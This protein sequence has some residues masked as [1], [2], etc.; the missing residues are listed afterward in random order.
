[1]RAFFFTLLFLFSLIANAQDYYEIDTTT[2]DVDLQLNGFHYQD[3]SSTLLPRDVISKNWEKLD[4]APAFS[5]SEY[6]HWFKYS[7]TNPYS[8]KIE[9]YFFI[10][11][12]YIKEIDVYAVHG[13]SIELLIQTGTSRPFTN[14]DLKSSGYPIRITLEANDT[15]E[16]I[17]KFKHLYLPL[18]ATTFLVS[19]ETLK[20][21]IYKSFSLLW[22]W[23]G[24]YST[25]FLIALFFYLF[26]RQKI[27]LYY[28]LL[29]IGI[30]LYIAIQ[31]GEFFLFFNIDTASY[32]SIFDFS[33][34][35]LIN[36]FF[37][38]FI[39]KLTPIKKRNPLI[40]K[41]M[42]YLIYGLIIIWLIRLLP[43]ARHSMFMHYSHIYILSVTIILY[44][45][46]PILLIRSIIHK[47]K[48][49]LVLFVIYSFYVFEAFIETILP[50]LGIFSDSQFVNYGILIASLTEMFAFMFLMAKEALTVYRERE[51]LL[52][53]KQEHQT[54]L[55]Q[56]I[57][58][59][60]EDERTR[61]GRELHDSLGANMAIIKQ[62]VKR[63]DVALFSIVSQ[64]IEMVRNLSHSL[65]TPQIN[66]E[67][68]KDELRELCHIFS[69]EKM[70]VH[71][72]FYEWPNI[73]DSNITTHLYRIVQELINNAVKHSQAEN[74][75]LQFMG[76][77]DNKIS[78]IYEDDGV[79]FNPIQQKKGL[80]LKNIT[81][82]LEL[83]NGSMRI[84]SS[85]AT[86]GTT[87]FIDVQL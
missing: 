71:Y 40:W 76:E 72:Y 47:D 7:I 58:R 30:G 36:I 3:T 75:Y 44:L 79:G 73:E 13:D 66:K 74:T 85:K 25:I 84:D 41:W 87:I 48:N 54:E 18:R 21:T 52:L 53:E 31:L 64:S 67:D 77:S 42:F 68:F 16:Y 35:L 83:L 51:K 14:K 28:I 39:N 9:R 56:S 15:V 27:F 69:N 6:I 49:A 24:V 55:I 33:G 78:I 43:D 63:T 62:H 81:Y 65:I 86:K 22:L 20:K 11:Y 29:N 4:I 59:S 2:N 23:K 38:L 50:N 60:Q 61:V 46:H 19:K 32:I 57:V 82:R 5:S 45:L 80:G 37:P 10:P 1:M 17:F 70:T 8:T 34:S 12:H 26:L